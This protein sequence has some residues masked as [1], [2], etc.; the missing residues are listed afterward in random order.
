[1]TLNQRADMEGGLD[2]L[3]RS[4]DLDKGYFEGSEAGPQDWRK[5][6]TRL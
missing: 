5:K 4:Q 2:R 6:L 3:Y 1:M